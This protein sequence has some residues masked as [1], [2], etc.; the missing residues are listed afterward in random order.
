[1]IVAVAVVSGF[2]AAVKEK[3]FSFMGHVHV[4]L[5]DASHSNTLTPK[6]IYYDREIEDSIRA[7]PHVVQVL[8][9]VQR[10]VIAQAHG[11]MEGLKLKGVNSNYRLPESVVFKGAKID[12]SDTFYSKQII[13]SQTTANTLNV[14]IGDTIQLDFLEPNSMPRIRRVRIAGIFHTGMEEVDKNFALCDIRLLQRMNGWTADS[15]NGYQADLDDEAYAD[16][17]AGFIH[18]YIIAPPLEAYTTTE[19][20]S[21]IFDW[22]ELQGMNGQILLI[23]MAIVSIINMGAVL[24]ILMVDRASMIGLLKALGMSFGATRNIFLNIAALIGVGGIAL[25]N[26]LAIGLCWLQ[27]R[28]GIIKLSEDVYYMKYAPVKL[29]WWEIITIDIVTLL[30]IVLCMWIPTFYIRRIQP[31]R[32]LQFK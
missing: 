14:N 18:E 2:N 22:L 6:P 31:A 10:P 4:I 25:G 23:I 19:N 15:I 16:T 1:M 3:L 11:T 13:L 30:L 12:Y 7:L 20:F 29:V 21:F 28:F 24:V 8:P 9:F 32:V 17:T 26:I 27:S 5:F